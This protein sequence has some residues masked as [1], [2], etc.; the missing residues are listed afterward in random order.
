[1]PPPGGKPAPTI[2]G[3]AADPDAI[4]VAG[5]RGLPAWRALGAME[6]IVRH[7]QMPVFNE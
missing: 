4:T 2:S 7:L 5:N 3:F 6:A 1:M